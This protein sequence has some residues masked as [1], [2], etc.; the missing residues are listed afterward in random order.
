VAPPYPCGRRR[1][2]RKYTRSQQLGTPADMRRD[3]IERAASA[4]AQLVTK[5]ECGDLSPNQRHAAV[6]A[7]QAIDMRLLDLRQEEYTAQK[8]GVP[9]GALVV[10]G[11]KVQPWVHGL[12]LERP[13]CRL[14]P[15]RQKKGRPEAP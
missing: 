3:M 8:K 14:V 9:R 2:P 13:R 15:C 11:N 4:R 6:A 12:T 7:L 10:A 5:L 1:V